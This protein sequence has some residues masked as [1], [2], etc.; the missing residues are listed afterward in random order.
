MNA[1]SVIRC[2]TFVESFAHQN[3]TNVQNF[4]CAVKIFYAKF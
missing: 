1:T 4:I 2:K 3:D